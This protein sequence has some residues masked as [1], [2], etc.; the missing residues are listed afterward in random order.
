MVWPQKYIKNGPSEKN[1]RMQL[2][3]LRSHRPLKT[4]LE[5]VM[6]DIRDCRITKGMVFHKMES[7]R[8]IQ[9][10]DPDRWDQW[11]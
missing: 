1:Q 7:D 2:E 8:R 9:K 5:E 10:A 3:G 4:W 11:L 6:N